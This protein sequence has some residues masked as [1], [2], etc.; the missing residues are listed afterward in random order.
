MKHWILIH[1]YCKTRTKQK[2]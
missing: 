2:S 1:T